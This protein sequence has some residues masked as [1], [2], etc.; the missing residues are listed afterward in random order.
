MQLLPS[1]S[2]F[3]SIF[4]RKREENEI[5]QNFRPINKLE[6]HLQGGLKEKIPNKDSAG[7][8]KFHSKYTQDNALLKDLH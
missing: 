3:P 1:V 6:H 8:S 4:I 5:L 7:G 2:P